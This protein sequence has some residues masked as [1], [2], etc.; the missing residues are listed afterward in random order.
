MEAFLDN[1]LAFFNTPLGIMILSA[2]VVSLG[3]KK[4]LEKPY[5]KK[6][7]GAIKSSVKKAEKDVPGDAKNTS[8]MKQSAAL[9]NTIKLW[10][11]KHNGKEPSVKIISSFDEGVRITHDDLES[12]GRLR[13]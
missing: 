11:V 6:Y 13:K 2:I 1:L 4:L 5:W 3:G 12:K 7:E 9:L 10:K 8:E